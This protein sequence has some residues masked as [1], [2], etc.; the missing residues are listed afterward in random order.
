MVKIKNLLVIIATPVVMISAAC[1]SDATY[2]STSG[3]C[4]DLS[5]V[6]QVVQSA[7]AAKYPGMT[8]CY[9]SQPYGYEAVFTQGGIEYEGEFTAS[10]QWLETEYEVAENQFSGVVL[11]KV[12]QERPGYEI[13]KREIEITPQGTFYEVEIES[14]GTQLELYFDSQGNPASN[15]NEDS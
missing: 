12:R 1:V 15:S 7:F 8:A 11:Q 13:T 6:P 2:E 4:L 14:D 5:Q 10:G 9:E 3:D